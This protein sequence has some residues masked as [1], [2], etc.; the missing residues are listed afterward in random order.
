MS[1]HNIPEG[2]HPRLDGAEAHYPPGGG[3]KCDSC[4]RKV[5]VLYG[6]ERNWPEDKDLEVCFDCLTAWTVEHYSE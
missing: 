3:R 6:Y 2:Y 4:G 5:G 1:K